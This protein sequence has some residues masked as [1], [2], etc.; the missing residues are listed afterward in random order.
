MRN[1]IGKLTLFAAGV[2]V[3]VLL[4]Q[5]GSAQENG[6][7][8]LRLSHVGVYAKDFNE[9]LRFYTQTLG[10]H[11]AFSVKDEKGNL[12]FTYLQIAR[13]TFL[14]LTPST[15]EHPPGLS[16]VGIWPAD[17]SATVAALRKHGLKVDD[18]RMASN[19]VNI[20]NILDPNG[21][22]LELLDYLPGSPARKAMDD[23]K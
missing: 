3:G 8:A 9:S 5:P 21:V 14:E 7:P 6:V 15:P 19:Q 23:W 10:L 22:R 16:H 11:E 2:G 18:P 13:D 12:R 4:M 17:L 1:L 20:T